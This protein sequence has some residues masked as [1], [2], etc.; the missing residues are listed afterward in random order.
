MTESLTIVAIL[1]ACAALV[2]VAILLWRARHAEQPHATLMAELARQQTD[3]AARLDALMRH[4]T[5]SQSQLQRSVN[6][7]LD[8]VSHRLG[9]LLEKTK[10]ST[11][12]NS[13]K[14]Q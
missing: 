3:L 10:L 8:S 14:A 9:D 2:V 12:E 13:A 5:N 6:E 1:V 11:T 4:L 7:R